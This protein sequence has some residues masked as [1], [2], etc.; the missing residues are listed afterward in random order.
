MSSG[1]LRARCAQKGDTATAV[2][3][4]AL[5]AP[6]HEYGL[7]LAAV[8]P[9]RLDLKWLQRTVDEQRARNLA[10]DFVDP[11]ELTDKWWFRLED[12]DG[13]IVTPTG[14]NAQKPCR[15]YPVQE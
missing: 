11:R 12:R 1:P 13:E 2:S 7:A 15:D 14:K 6:Q 3:A 5:G 10:N 9:D 4:N 8:G